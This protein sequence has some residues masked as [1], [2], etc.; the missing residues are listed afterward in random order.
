MQDMLKRL[1]RDGDGKLSP[2]ELPNAQRFKQ[3]DANGD[4]FVTLEEAAKSF[5]GGGAAGGSSRPVTGKEPEL[6]P[7]ADRAF[8]DFKFT[9]DYF[10]GRQP[11]DSALAKATEANALVP[12]N[13]MLYCCVS[14]MCSIWLRRIRRSSIGRACSVGKTCSPKPANF[15]S[16]KSLTTVS[17]AKHT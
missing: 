3:M 2:Q 6:H 14:Y 1:D 5:S 9:T 4:G 8:L 13:G 17:P 7:P 12:H 16:R 15:S 11:A 10:A